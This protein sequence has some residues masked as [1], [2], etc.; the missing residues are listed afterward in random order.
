MAFNFFLLGCYAQPT[1]PADRLLRRVN[2][3][4]KENFAMTEQE[5]EIVRLKM[6]IEALYV[7]FF[8]VCNALGRTSPDFL[9]TLLRTAKEKQ[10]EYQTVVLKGVSPGLSDLMAGEFQ[11]A[12]NDLIS[13]MENSFSKPYIP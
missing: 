9:P 3:N 12:F 1:N 10:L 4:V 11:E 6:K 2:S 8:G 13:Q 5:L 7:I